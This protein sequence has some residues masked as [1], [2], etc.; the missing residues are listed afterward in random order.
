M[1]LAIRPG[2]VAGLRRAVELATSSWGGQGFPIVEVG[3]DARAAIALAVAMGV[4]CLF[5][6]DDDDNVK[7]LARKPG[8]EWVPSWQGLSPFSRDPEGRH[9]HVLPA[10]VLYD[11]YRLSRRPPACHVTWPHGHELGDLRT[12]WF[13]R[14]AD[15]AAGVAD[16]LSFESVAQGCPLGPGL[17]LPPYPASLTSQLAVTMQDVFQEPQLEERGIV[18]VEEGN[19]GHLVA[20]WN[21]RACGQGVFP[22]SEAHADLLEE[23]LRQ[24][25][26]ETASRPL[27]G[28]GL[29]PGLPVW[30]PAR[31]DSPPSFTVPPLPP[32]LAGAIDASRF[33][34]MPQPHHV[35]LHACGPL[36]TSH[37]RRF[38]VDT[39][40]GGEAVIPLP[41]LDFLP[42]RASWTDL[43]MVAADI[44]IWTEPPDP[45][46]ETAIVALQ[47]QSPARRWCTCPRSRRWSNGQAGPAPPSGPRQPQAPGWRHRAA[48]HAG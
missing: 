35:D 22:W 29:L 26:D 43:G 28:G 1:G 37:V 25:L 40:H 13:G 21:L 9:E 32:R 33:R 36:L 17:P 6:V 42:R 3:A 31:E 23:P 2:S 8:F 27:D 19:V 47:L 41:A 45:L 15:D 30:L 16:R 44:E 14:F 5:P 11:W 18:V 34:L 48:A 39:G 12:V 46:G 7:A 24:W 38:S 20:F 10:S 4:D